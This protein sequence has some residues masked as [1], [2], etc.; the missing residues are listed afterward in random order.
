M[1]LP[2]FG[3]HLLFVASPAK[4]LG[5]PGL[6]A[7]LA[8][9]RLFYDSD[10]RLCGNALRF[11]FSAPDGPELSADWI[12]AMAHSA[13]SSGGIMLLEKQLDAE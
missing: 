4:H 8:M 13:H 11:V 6:G 10:P 3:P 2:I 1:N 7:I 9:S 5:R 12:T